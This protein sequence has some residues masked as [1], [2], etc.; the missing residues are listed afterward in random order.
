VA[1]RR[2]IHPVRKHQPSRFLQP[3]L[4]LILERTHCR[5]RFEMVMKGRYAHRGDPREIVNPERLRIVRP[6]PVYGACDVPALTI[7]R[8]QV[9]QSRSLLAN[10]KTIQHFALHKRGNNRDV[11]RHVEQP[12]Q[13]H[14]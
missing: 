2:H 6:Q 4:F 9:P 10:E 1:G 13:S 5:N 8:Y 12:R 14:E 7:G 11:T 3:Q